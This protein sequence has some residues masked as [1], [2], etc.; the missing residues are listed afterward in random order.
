MSHILI[1]ASSAEDWKRFLAK[2]TQFQPGYSAHSLAHCWHACR[3][4]PPEIA[5]VLG[6]APAL[7]DAALLLAIP[8]HKVSLPGRGLPSQTDLWLLLR[9]SDGLVSVAIEG[10]VAEPFGPTIE[11]WLASSK[12]GDDRNRRARLDGLCQLLG[13]SDPPPKLRYQL[14]HRTASAII[15]ARRFHAQ[16]AA[17][18][19][20][21][22]SQDDAWFG[23]F[24]RFVEA[25]GGKAQ[26][27]HLTE[28][29]GRTAPSLYIGWV[30][31]KAQ[32]AKT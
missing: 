21:S 26:H 23:D 9:T 11:E 5:E 3:G 13:I 29:F 31:G 30:R 16:R 27:G 22:F 7:K 20:H 17:M 15:E 24:E 8:E 32:F 4:L 6:T 14:L 2:D 10:K 25:L 19:V 28:I 12:D 1:P 18:L